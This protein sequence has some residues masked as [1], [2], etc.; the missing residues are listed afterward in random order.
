MATEWN[1]KEEFERLV[2]SLNGDRAKAKAE[3]ARLYEDPETGKMR[4]MPR[5]ADMMNQFGGNEGEFVTLE[6]LFVEF[7]TLHQQVNVKKTMVGKRMGKKFVYTP[8]SSEA[9]TIAGRKGGAARITQVRNDLIHDSVFYS[10]VLDLSLI[11]I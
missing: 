8:I 6:R 5:A 11:H 2:V 1:T 10:S 4:A 7:R 3:W 9:E